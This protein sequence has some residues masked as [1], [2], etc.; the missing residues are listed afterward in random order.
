MNKF[1]SVV[2]FLTLALDSAMAQE[3]GDSARAGARTETVDSAS[4]FTDFSCVVKDRNKVEVRWAADSVD[5]G[6]YFVVERSNDGNRFETVGALMVAGT[7]PEYELTDNAPNSGSNYYR[8]KYTAK[9]GRPAFTKT[10]RV[11]LSQAAAFRF[12]PN[13]VDKLLIIQTDHAVFV[14]IVS[15]FGE[16]RIS[17]QVQ[18]G[19]QV[20]NVAALEKGNYLLRVSDKESNRDILEQL[21]KN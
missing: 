15:S 7:A 2:L 20:I 3:T 21:L 13:P 11:I 19:V 18:P 8:V 16:V 9:N 6:N 14:Q 1:F 5:A 4:V 10:A 12:Y 17:K